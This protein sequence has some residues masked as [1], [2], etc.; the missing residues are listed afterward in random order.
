MPGR[1]LLRVALN[2]A[3][4]LLSK[5]EGRLRA[6]FSEA[7][8]DQYVWVMKD[9]MRLAT[10]L[11]GRS[12]SAVELFTDAGL[13]GQALASGQDSTCARP[14]SAWL[15]AQRR[16]V[17]R[18]F[19]LLMADELA[20]AG[21]SDAADRVTDALRRV[22]EP[23]GTRF[24][25]P[26]GWPRG[27]GGPMPTEEQIE[28]LR[29]QMLAEP[30]WV[31]L[32]N[33][34]IIMILVTRGQ[35]IGALLRLDGTDLHRLPDGQVRM[36]LQAKSSREPF[37]LAV[38]HEVQETVEAYISTYNDWARVVGKAERI[39][40]GISGAVWRNVAGQRLS[41]QQ[42]TAE[43]SMACKLAKVPHVTSHGFRR[44]FASRATVRVPRSIAALA[45][46]WRSP[47]R[48]DD[49]YVQPSLA[50]LQHQLVMLSST[51][52]RTPD[53]LP[54]QAFAEVG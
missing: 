43:L 28:S 46:N 48:M 15:A 42:W 29:R 24:R 47:R 45:G 21:I 37:E 30:G 25:L 11:S 4:E 26:V 53:K 36:C 41:Y 2:D 18:S 12:V 9:L 40:F 35:R 14:I 44:A 23:V 16:S 33:A 3:E 50:R 51:R 6:R 19:A 54:V 7:G 32:R 22:A 13:M 49:H 31:G 34:A 1:R 39:G 5:F 17:A 38:P 10:T 27:R 20:M 8:A 52:T